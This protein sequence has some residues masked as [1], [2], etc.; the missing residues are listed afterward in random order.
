MPELNIPGSRIYMPFVLITTIVI[1]G[2][3]GFISIE[4]YN[5][6]DAFYMT[7]ITIATVGF[8]EVHPL[9]EQGRL[10]T[11]FLIITSFGTFAYAITAISKYVVDGEFN[12][13]YQ[14]RRVSAGIQKLNE[15]V[16]VC[17]YGRNGKQ[18]VI[19][20]ASSGYSFVV[21]E[22]DPVAL[23][24]LRENGMLYV[25]GDATHDDILERAG[26]Q[27]AK[28]LITTL[29]VDADNLFIVLSARTINE[30]I[31]IISRLPVLIM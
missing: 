12:K 15:H 14:I 17:G 16:I 18:S 5:F 21:I 19:Q 9:T 10:F 28:A 4:G 7:V 13:Y 22:K 1:I 27:R 8:Q 26:I 11:S 25:E 29:P 30:G 24:H 31:T 3:L 2:V 20:L 23:Q 6:L